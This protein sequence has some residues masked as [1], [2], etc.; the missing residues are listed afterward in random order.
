[1]YSLGNTDAFTCNADR[2]SKNEKTVRGEKKVVLNRER[3]NIIA[4]HRSHKN[5]LRN[6]SLNLLS[7]L[8]F[9]LTL[10]F[11]VS[12]SPHLQEILLY[13]YIYYYY[14]YYSLREC[15]YIIRTNARANTHVSATTTA[16]F[17]H[18]FS[19]AFEG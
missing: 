8:L 2:I 18:F 17:A 9:P 19:L 1:M 15:K 12:G 6:I 11:V 3:D 14:Y 7:Y 13:I 4:R 10:T 5:L 16:A